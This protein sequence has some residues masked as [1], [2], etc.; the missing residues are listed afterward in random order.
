MFIF[1]ARYWLGSVTNWGA[2]GRRTTKKL[3][4][5]GAVWEVEI[6]EWG[7]NGEKREEACDRRAP[8]VLLNEYGDV[9]Q[10][11]DLLPDMGAFY[12][13]TN[14]I[15][16]PG[17]RYKH[18]RSFQLA[19]REYAIR[20][21]FELGIEVSS[22]IKFQGYCKGGDYPWRINVRPEI[23]GAPTNHLSMFS[24]LSWCAGRESQGK[25]QPKD[26]F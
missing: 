10:C 22:P 23:H 9:L 26:G 7:W 25:I 18:M 17:S 20:N 24:L 1:Y 15:R 2:M 6:E 14:P 3:F 16:C 5:R 19:R 13:W 12:D 4:W 8:V 11:A 21:E